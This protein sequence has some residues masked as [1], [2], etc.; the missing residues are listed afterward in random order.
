MLRDKHNFDSIPV[1]PLRH[2]PMIR[3]STLNLDLCHPGIYSLQLSC[4]D[5]LT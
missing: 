4:H 1:A 5:L 2:Y 3:L